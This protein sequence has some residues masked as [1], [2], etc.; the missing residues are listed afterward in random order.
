MSEHDTWTSLLI[1]PCEYKLID[2]DKLMDDLESIICVHDNVVSLCSECIKPEE[3]F[4]D[5]DVSEL[6]PLVEC[7][8]G[9]L[10][11]ECSSR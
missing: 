8:H 4:M 6:E 9:C 7:E 1:K 10:E 3:T 2:I 5:I 11:L